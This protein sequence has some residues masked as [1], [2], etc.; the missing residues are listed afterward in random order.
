MMFP[1]R[2]LSRQQARFLEDA[3]MLGDRRRGNL[4]RL[5]EV[6]DRGL[7]GAQACEDAAAD[8]M[9][10]GA[11]DE[12]ELMLVIVLLPRGILRARRQPLHRLVL[13]QKGCT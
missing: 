10:Q 9:G 12:I 11:E 5:G 6:R 3:H 7:A 8:R 1:P 2:L 4:E 13:P